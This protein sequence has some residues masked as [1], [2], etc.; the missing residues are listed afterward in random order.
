MLKGTIE[1]D[2]FGKHVIDVRYLKGA[3][4]PRIEEKVTIPTLSAMLENCHLLTSSKEWFATY[5]T[6]ATDEHRAMETLIQFGSHHFGFANVSYPLHLTNIRIAS[7]DGKYE[8]IGSFDVLAIGDEPEYRMA[9]KTTD[10]LVE[11]V[12]DQSNQHKCELSMDTSTDFISHEWL[13]QLTVQ[14]KL[15]TL[16]FDCTVQERC[17]KLKDDIAF[18]SA[19]GQYVSDL[20]VINNLCIQGWKRNDTLHAEVQVL[21]EFNLPFELIPAGQLTVSGKQAITSCTWNVSPYYTVEQVLLALRVPCLLS[22]GIKHDKVLSLNISFCF[23]LH[24]CMVQLEVT[25]V[26][27][28]DAKIS[29]YQEHNLPQLLLCSRKHRFEIDPQLPL[30]M[31]EFPHCDTNMSWYRILPHFGDVD[32][33]TQ[34]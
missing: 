6:K 20:V 2:L 34:N 13:S 32:I 21:N 3:P 27:F 25:T 10:A 4:V 15:V 12:F 8:R 11:L 19:S 16:A 23:T 17:I 5:D 30:Q 24:S 14:P 7:H 22:N 29:Y 9:G 1:H 28:G 18:R 33:V 26:P 31:Q